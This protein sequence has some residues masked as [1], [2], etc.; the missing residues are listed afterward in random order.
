M[1]LFIVTNYKLSCKLTDLLTD[2]DG[3]D[4]RYT[5]VPKKRVDT[6]LFEVLLFHW[7]N[8][9]ILATE[10]SQCDSVGGKNV[11]CW[12]QDQADQPGK[13]QKNRFN[14]FYE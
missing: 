5:T 8:R 3:L 7:G 9:I 14:E 11:H 1:L 13:F 2:R 12:G 10:A 6:K 4:T